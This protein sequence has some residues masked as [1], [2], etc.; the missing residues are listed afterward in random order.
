VR[1]IAA[2]AMRRRARNLRFL[3]AARR[4]GRSLRL[5]APLLTVTRPGTPSWF[6]VWTGLSSWPTVAGLRNG[7]VEA[8][9]T[10]LDAADAEAV[11][12]LTAALVQEFPKDK[13]LRELA[14]LDALLRG[15]PDEAEEHVSHALEG[16]VAWRRANA[17]HRL[18]RIRARLTLREAIAAHSS[19]LDVARARED[20]L[21]A[22]LTREGALE[23]A[24]EDYVLPHLA[25]VDATLG[26]VV[27][28]LLDLGYLAVATDDDLPGL[29]A[30]LDK[31]AASA[32]E[33][34]FPGALEALHKVPARPEALTERYLL[35]LAR[36]LAAV[37]RYDE[38]RLV[39]H[40]LGGS[41]AT[42][43]VAAARE[44]HIAW[45]VHDYDGAVE[46]ARKATRAGMPSRSVRGVRE[47]SLE[48]LTPADPPAGGVGHVAFYV[49]QGENFGDVALPAAVRTSIEEAAGPL[50]WLPFHAHQVF[51]DSFVR[52]ANTQRAL[53]VGGGGLFLPDTAPNGNSG[54]QWNVPRSSLEAIEVPLFVYSVGY[55]LFPGQEFQGSLFAGS[56]EALARK[57][58]FMGL[59]NHGSMARV[60]DMLPAELAA[61]VRYIP[62]PTTV[63]ERL[64]DDLPEKRPGSGRVL[65]NAAFDR[66]ARRF[67]DTYP[68]FLEQMRDFV[69]A[70]EKAGAE[71]RFVAHTRG[72]LRLA[73][74]LQE[75]FGLERP[76][77]ALHDMSPDGAYGVYR[78]A[79]LVIGMRG[80]ATMIP[81]G[82]GTP[83][84]SI[85]S[86]PKMRYFLEDI[87]RVEW[88][89]DVHDQRLGARLTELTADILGREQGY[90]DDIHTLQDGLLVP[91]RAAA[92][93][94]AAALDH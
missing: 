76:V 46:A 80:H 44:A 82:L 40:I 90:R 84:L 47:R 73:N 26:D 34:D 19:S 28:P 10:S 39:L 30:V 36:C 94:I 16:S 58:E 87:G 1:G 45:V 57:A 33:A 85:V 64:R 79:S 61:R 35:E 4:T 92:A 89:V 37:S 75:T 59:R 51:D 49:D 14:A 22:P 43:G 65:V 83:V 38:A 12:P 17:G 66:S 60:T 88:G 74:D 23:R 42:A 81:F 72:D 53:V 52:A 56:L 69:E 91:V 63:L 78:S 20:A 3:A 48:P 5:P 55:N 68:A 27:N 62:C 24:A 70:A 32:D 54:W 2:A 18:A 50:E 29:N 25:R 86:H 8:V 71:V 13:A 77:D 41:E 67:G 93:D 6:R 15:L 7:A 31:A 9:R 11:A 21:A